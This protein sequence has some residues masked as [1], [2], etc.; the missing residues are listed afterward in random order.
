MTAH[1]PA[2]SLGG[3]QLGLGLSAGS[4]GYPGLLMGAA[5]QTG[6]LLEAEGRLASACRVPQDPEWREHTW[7]D[8][9]PSSAMSLLLGVLASS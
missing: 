9:S 1:L 6:C 2:T 7:L 4:P 5:A 3:V 8:Q